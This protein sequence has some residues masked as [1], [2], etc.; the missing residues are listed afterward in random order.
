MKV[1]RHDLV[2]SWRSRVMRY[3]E[4]VFFAGGPGPPGS[5]RVNILQGRCLFKKKSACHCQQFSEEGGCLFKT[6][7]VIVDRF[8]NKEGACLKQ[9]VSLLT[10]FGTR[11]VLV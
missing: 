10:V 5:Q 7:C 8:W 1:G 9:S 2:A 11:R 3:R 4:G 6:E